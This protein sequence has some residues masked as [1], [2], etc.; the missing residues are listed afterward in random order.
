M[1]TAHNLVDIRG[2]ITHP[3]VDCLHHLASRIKRL[4]YPVFINIGAGAGTSSVA[5]LEGNSEAIVYSIDIRTTER[6]D[7]TNEHLQIPEMD[8]RIASRIIRIWGDSKAV[9]KA[10]PYGVDIVFVDGD[11]GYDGVK[12]DISAWY[13]TIWAGGIIAFH[14]YGIKPSDGSEQFPSVRRAVDEFKGWAHP[15]LI[16][17]TDMTI[18]FEV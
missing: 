18:A 16:E 5:L 15:K 12:G 14:D 10:W 9:G 6:E 7:E 1:R 17:H 13:E 11:H 8:P 2:Y 4:P 3:E